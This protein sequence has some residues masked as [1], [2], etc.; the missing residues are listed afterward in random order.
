MYPCFQG[1][2][3]FVSLLFPLIRPRKVIHYGLI[4]RLIYF[5][6]VLHL[7][8]AEF[9]D[10]LGKIKVSCLSN[11]RQT[12]EVDMNFES[13]MS[14]RSMNSKDIAR[15]RKIQLGALEKVTNHFCVSAHTWIVKYWCMCLHQMYTCICY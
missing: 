14:D 6:H 2:M 8:I 9:K 1:Y 13:E 11:P 12:I 7:Y 3:I 10:S 15:K 5:L 4:S